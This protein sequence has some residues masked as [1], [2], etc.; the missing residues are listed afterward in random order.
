MSVSGAGEREIGK[1]MRLSRGMA[2]RVLDQRLRL[3]RLL[4]RVCPDQD[5]L[6]PV[7]G[8]H[9]EEQVSVKALRINIYTT[10]PRAGGRSRVRQ[11]GYG[12]RRSQFLD[13]GSIFRG[14]L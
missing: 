7:C 9:V 6:R 11:I 4:A 13:F 2:I 5:R 3:S 8:E 1:G 10:Y 12:Y 14:K